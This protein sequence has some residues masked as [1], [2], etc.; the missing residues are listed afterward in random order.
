[1]ISNYLVLAERIR[2]EIE[3]IKQLIARCEAA[4]AAAS[5]RPEEIDFYFDSAALNLHDVY[6]AME[7]IFEQIA[8]RVDK[9]IPSGNDWHR[10]LLRQMSVDLAD[11]RTAVLSD[12]SVSELDEFLRFRHVVRNVYTHS[13]RN[14]EIIKLVRAVRP[15]FER[16]QRELLEFIVFLERIGKS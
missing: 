10:E 14:E 13:F 5:R 4:V 6:V 11:I 8:S 15:T 9:S 12:N 3:E 7:R 2:Q 1:L 16:V